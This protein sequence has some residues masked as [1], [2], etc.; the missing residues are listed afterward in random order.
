MRAKT[1]DEFLENLIELLGM[2]PPNIRKNIK[3]TEYLKHMEEV[4][5]KIPRKSFEEV[6]P[7]APPEAIDLIKKLM[8][9]DPKDRLTAR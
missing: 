5:E 7:D 4:A 8:T 1:V 2:P 3:K 6:I 9:Y